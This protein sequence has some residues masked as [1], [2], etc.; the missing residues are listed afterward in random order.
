[1]NRTGRRIAFWVVLPIVSLC[2]PGGT[3]GDED[4]EREFFAGQEAMEQ[5]YRDFERE[6]FATFRREVLA[7]WNDFVT[8]TKKDWVEYAPDRTGRSRVD[9]ETGEVLVEVVVPEARA[10]A[11]PAIVDR[12]LMEEVERLVTDHGKMRDYPV[13]APPAAQPPTVE[14]PEHR[15]SAV[16]PPPVEPAVAEPPRQA[17]PPPLLPEPVLKDQLRDRA[18]DTV[19]EENKVAFAREVVQTRPVSRETLTTDAGKAVKA[20][21]RFSLVPDHLRIRGEQYLEGVRKH[22]ARFGIS[23]PLAFAVIHTESYFNPKATSPV[24]AYGLMQLVPR[25]GARDAYRYVHGEDRILPADY[26]Y[27]PDHNIELGCA[28]LGLLQGR[29]FKG[30]RDPR[31]ALYCSIAAYNTG[32]GNVSRTL[33]GTTRLGPA[34]ERI[35]RMDPDDLYTFLGEHLPYGETRAYLQKVRDRMALYR[36]WE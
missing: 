8:S 13:P 25:S 21:V 11:D 26:L 24:P 15:V 28:Y 31:N 5:D 17:E 29:Y 4:L 35:N 2:L 19:T 7:M 33:A 9:F 12:R 36:E 22:S 1:M 20:Q 16:E 30:V 10:A 23:V 27:V 14:P 32:A 6:A 34:I 18:G 3:R